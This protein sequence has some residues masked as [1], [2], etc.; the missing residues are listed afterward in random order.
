MFLVVFSSYNRST[1][2]WFIMMMNFWS[3]WKCQ[4]IHQTRLCCNANV[5]FNPTKCFSTSVCHG[6]TVNGS[7]SKKVRVF[8]KGKIKCLLL[9]SMP[10][11]TKMSRCCF[12]SMH[13]SYESCITHRFYMVFKSI[14]SNNHL[15]YRIV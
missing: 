4:H 5:C 12:F 10:L 3:S 6:R 8:L 13:P 14:S 15:H 2:S 11:T 9:T 1:F 7:Y